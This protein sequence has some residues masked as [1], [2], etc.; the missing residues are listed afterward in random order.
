METSDLVKAI[1][2]IKEDCKYREFDE[3]V[4]EVATYID[5][6]KFYQRIMGLVELLDIT[7]ENKK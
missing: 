5:C 4:P 7:S 1:N 3:S 2:N 6:N